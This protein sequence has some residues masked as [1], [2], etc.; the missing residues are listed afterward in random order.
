MTSLRKV[1]GDRV[2]NLRLV[3]GMT[4]EE[5]AEKAGLHPTYIGIIERGEQSA[6][7]DTVEKLAKA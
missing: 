1:F 6:T 7:L 5:L 4:Q 2:R 3:K